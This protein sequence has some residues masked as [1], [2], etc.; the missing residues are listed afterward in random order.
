M[1]KNERIRILRK[2]FNKLF[3]KLD[4]LIKSTKREKDFEDVID[5]IHL[6]YFIYHKVNDKQKAVEKL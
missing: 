3:E 1:T 2:E 4:R 5:V 6:F